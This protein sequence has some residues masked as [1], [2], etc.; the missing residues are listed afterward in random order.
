[1]HSDAEGFKRFEQNRN[2][3]GQGVWHL[4]AFVV[5]QSIC[6]VAR[7]ER[8]SPGRAPIAI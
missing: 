5:F 3:W 6:L 7:E 2:L 1:M 4:F 8:D